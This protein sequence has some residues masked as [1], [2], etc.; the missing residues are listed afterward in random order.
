MSHQPCLSGLEPRRGIRARDLSENAHNNTCNHTTED[1]MKRITSLVVALS[2]MAIAVPVSANNGQ[3]GA[4]A[5]SAYP[6]T[7]ASCF[8]T[9]DGYVENNNSCAGGQ[10]WQVLLPVTTSG[11]Y[12]PTVWYQQDLEVDPTATVQC[13]TI[14]VSDNGQTVS[15]TGLVA[16]TGDTTGSFQPGAETVATDGY[17]IEAC[18][19]TNNNNKD[20]YIYSIVW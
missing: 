17:L 11:S 20:T 1:L 15:A 19:L 14:A 7:D 3:I 4:A 16:A 18:E 13:N 10:V 8:T 5:G 2:C 9:T 6:L 12:N